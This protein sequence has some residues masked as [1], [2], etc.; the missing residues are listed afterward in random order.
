VRVFLG[1][2]KGFF[3]ED[4]QRG[5]ACTAQTG[6]H[7][8]TLSSGSGFKRIVGI[9][10]RKAGRFLSRDRLTMS[11]KETD[12]RGTVRVVIIAGNEVS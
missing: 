8:E 12:E 2:L 10:C 3:V 4:K 9:F 7:R 6:R 1:R 11:R 5:L